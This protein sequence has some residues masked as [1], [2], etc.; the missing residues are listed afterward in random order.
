MY[1]IVSTTEDSI[2]LWDG[3]TKDPDHPD[4]AAGLMTV[5]VGPGHGLIVGQKVNIS[6]ILVNDV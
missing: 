2:T 1:I 4:K 5:F 6:I 3:K